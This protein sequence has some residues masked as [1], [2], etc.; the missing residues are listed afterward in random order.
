LNRVA[1]RSVSA[2]RFCVRD[3]QLG[4]RLARCYPS[5]MS[6]LR[7]YAG[8]ARVPFLLL[9]F[10]LVASGAAAA[11]YEG[12]FSWLRTLMAL[13]GL[14]ALHAAVNILNEWS[15]LRTGIDL[16]TVRTPFSGGS[17]TLPAGDMSS[18][19][20]LAFGVMAGGVGLVIGIW[21]VTQVGGIIVPIM[22][23]GAVCVLAYTPFLTA[24]GVGEVAAGLGLGALPVIGTAVVQ[25][26]SIPSAAIAA[27]VPAFFMTFNLLLL[28]EFPDE[29]A[30]RAG[31]RRHLV[32]LLGRKGAAAV[33][34]LAGL[35]TPTAIIVGT[36]M[37]ALP[38]YALAAVLPSLLL[39]RPLRWALGDAQAEVP[40][41][42]LGANVIWNLGTNVMLAVTLGIA[43][44]M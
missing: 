41:P 11:A 2:A 26:G 43:R 31:G 25:D 34:A 20:A 4:G 18:G 15:D 16:H 23:V 35:L 9:P 13:V 30:D 1:E 6:S 27:S 8:V 3:H 33:Y 28:N 14:V 12:H 42:A 29:A 32:I 7:A 19:A 36:A 40:V 22:I 21:F 37:N 17:G 10:T 24:S 5:P 44:L 38:L 39:I